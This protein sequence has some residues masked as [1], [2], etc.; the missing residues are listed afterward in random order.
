M[1]ILERLERRVVG[2]AL[3]WVRKRV[4]ERRPMNAFG[5]GKEGQSNV[6]GHAGAVSEGP[7]PAG[8]PSVGR[9]ADEHTI[10]SVAEAELG[11]RSTSAS[12]EAYVKGENPGGLHQGGKGPHYPHRG[13]SDSQIDEETTAAGGTPSTLPRS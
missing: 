4:Q 10:R 6:T 8:A 3:R 9:H 11:G 13:Q 1:N 12:R 2:P 5:R 7:R